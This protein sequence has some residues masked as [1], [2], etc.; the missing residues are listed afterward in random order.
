MKKKILGIFI[1]IISITLGCSFYFICFYSPP[2]N[3]DTDTPPTFHVGGFKVNDFAY[4]LQ[5]MELNEISTSL[6][7]LIIMDYSSDGTEQNEYTSSQ[8]KYMKEGNEKK[9]LISYMSIGE[10]E[11]YRFYWKEE[12]DSNEDGIPDVSAPEWL[13]NENPEW[14]GNYKVKYWDPDWQKIIYGTPNSYLDKIISAGFDGCYLDIIDAFEYYE[15]ERPTAQQ[16]MINF[17]IALSNYAKSIRANFLIISQNGES[18]L[19]HDDYRGAIDG[20]GR[21]DV[22]FDGNMKRTQAEI[23]Y[24]IDFLKLLLAENKLVMIVDYPTLPSNVKKFYHLAWQDGFLAH[25]PPRDLNDLTYYP[26]FPPD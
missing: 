16:D 24:V 9:L 6:Y 17:V 25:A 15:E 23:A 12:W 22:Y 8:V 3:S 19:E 11:N 14:E 2:S 1:I 20:I 21:E 26:D 5:N 10:A 7:D 18:L 13:D 4:Q